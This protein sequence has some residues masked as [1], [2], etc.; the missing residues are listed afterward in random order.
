MSEPGRDA[1]IRSVTGR[2]DL[3]GEDGAAGAHDPAA[4]REAEELLM[5]YL[6]TPDG[7]DPEVQYTVG[8]L[9]L[10]RAVTPRAATSRAEEAA[11]ADDSGEPVVALTLLAPFY[12]NPPGMPDVLPAGIRSML[13]I[14]PGFGPPPEDPAER[15]QAHAAAQNDLGMLLMGLRASGGQP[16]HARAAGAMLRTASSR[17]APGSPARAMALC[18]LGYAL[19]L[20]EPRPA[21]ITEA[22]TVLRESFAHTPSGDPNYARCA[23]GLG[24]A[25]LAASGVAQDR[26]VLAEA[27]GMLRLAV[28]SAPDGTA[29]LPQMLSDLGFAL[30]SHVSLEHGAAGGPGLAGDPDLVAEAAEAVE[31]LTRAAGL[32]PVSSPQR[33]QVLL[34]FADALIAADRPGEATELLVGN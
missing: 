24:L 11:A 3:A 1:L 14:I 28:R 15:T 25:L 34:R 30:T 2:I 6:A 5:R 31:V 29:N 19:M 8:V 20:G 32:L 9:Y 22:V 17:F 33:P 23:N 16:V 27:A 13:D 18:N 26:E 21:E 4:A 12:Q 10:L 7:T